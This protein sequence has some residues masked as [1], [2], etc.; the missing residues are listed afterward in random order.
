MTPAYSFYNGKKN[1]RYTYYRCSKSSRNDEGKCTP[2][3]ISGNV[4]EK[5]VFAQLEDILRRTDVLAMIAEG[6]GERKGILLEELDDT[7]KFWDSLLVGERERIIHLLVKDVLLCR[8]KVELTLTID[9]GAKRT[10][11]CQI[12]NDGGRT[13]II[14]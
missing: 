4:I 1:C 8:D 6:D 12:C 5:F 7:G 11:P 9:G 10:I 14:E 2:E 13:R 3:V